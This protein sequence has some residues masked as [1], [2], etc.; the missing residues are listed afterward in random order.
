MDEAIFLLGNKRVSPAIES[1]CAAAGFTRDDV[2]KEMSMRAIQARWA[3]EAEYQRRAY[4]Q[5]RD[6][7]DN[8][9]RIR[10]EYKPPS[11]EK[12][13]RKKAQDRLNGR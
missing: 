8:L 13:E 4:A 12:L 10:F 3:A 6:A 5:I 9:G 7:N 2:A 1:A 11:E